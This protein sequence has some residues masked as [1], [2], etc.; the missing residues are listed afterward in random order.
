MLKIWYAE[1]FRYQDGMRLQ[2]WQLHYATLVV[3]SSKD[4]KKKYSCE[5]FKNIHIFS[6]WNSSYFAVH[7]LAI[8]DRPVNMR[9]DVSDPDTRPVRAWHR[10]DT[11]TWDTPGLSLEWGHRPG[12]GTAFQSLC[13]SSLGGKH[14]SRLKNFNLNE[15]QILELCVHMAVSHH[16]WLYCFIY[17]IHLWLW[18]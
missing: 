7:C 1:G 4:D 3:F 5:I 6:D 14:Q 11:V 15:K 10:R 17:R 13:L 2:W 8:I 18:L 16:H 9:R 12:Q